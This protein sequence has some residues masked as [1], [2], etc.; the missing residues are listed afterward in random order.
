[1]KLEAKIAT[2]KPLHGVIET[3]DFFYTSGEFA[4]TVYRVYVFDDGYDL[5]DGMQDTLQFAKEQAEEHGIP[6]DA[7]QPANEP[8][9]INGKYR[10]H[11]RSDT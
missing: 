7:W 6:L 8:L 5:C 1:M 4:K 9:L 3:D 10:F 2:P 11:F